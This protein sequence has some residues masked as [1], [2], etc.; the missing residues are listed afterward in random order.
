MS[1]AAA[2][3][4][5]VAKP[6]V[7]R[8]IALRYDGGAGAVPR[9]TAKGEGELADTIIKVARE[10]GVPIE[11]NPLLAVALSQVELDEDIPPEL[12]TAV[13][14]VISFVLRRGLGES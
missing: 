7:K 3:P 4:L 6:G 2:D 10:A 8:A 11:D 9:V 13:A 14:E 1:D 5:Q 12:Y